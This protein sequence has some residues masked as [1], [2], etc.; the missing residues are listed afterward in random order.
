MVGY[1]DGQFPRNGEEKVGDIDAIAS[2]SLVKGWILEIVGNGT[3]REHTT[4]VDLKRNPELLLATDKEGHAPLA[5]SVS[6]MHNKTWKCLFEHMKVYGYG[7]LFL[8]QSGE[9]LV[10]L[11]ISCQDFR[12]ARRIINDYP[13][14]ILSNSDAVLTTLAQN[15]PRELIFWERRGDFMEELG[16]KIEP[17]DHR[18]KR[19][20]EY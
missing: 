1:I 7:A 11:A 19:V 6:N 12:L 10:V 4:V 15:F 2:D 17:Y 20:A 8:G 16:D 3:D 5:L 13:G 14:A 18:V 9:E